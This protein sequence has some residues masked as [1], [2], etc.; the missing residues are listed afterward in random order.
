VEIKHVDIP[1]EM[2]R[3]IAR[4]A[5]AE[6]ER[7]AKVIHA[8]GE[9]QAADK[10]NKAAKIIDETNVGIQLRYLQTLT[11]VATEK[12]STTIFPVPIDLFAPFIKKFE[13]EK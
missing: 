11:E 6:R 10:I 9:L 12:N 3:A 4:Q 5:E 7:R 13:K 1:Q 2:Q 8:E